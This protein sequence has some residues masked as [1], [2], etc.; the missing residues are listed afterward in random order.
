MEHFTSEITANIIFR[1]TG[2]QIVD[3]MFYLNERQ[4]VKQ[5]TRESTMTLFKLTTELT[6]FVGSIAAIDDA[7]AKL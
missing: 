5:R 2:I 6:F 3:T 7:I 4:G 1:W